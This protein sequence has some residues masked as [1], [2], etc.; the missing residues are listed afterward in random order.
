MNQTFFDG[1]EPY[2]PKEDYSKQRQPRRPNSWFQTDASQLAL[3]ENT[4]TPDVIS[5]LAYVGAKHRLYKQLM[6]E[7][8]PEDTSEIVSPFMGGAS[9]ELKLA[10]S[11]MKVWAYDIFRPV[12]EFFQ[13]FNEHA[14]QVVE[15]ALQIYPI[16]RGC[17]ETRERYEHLRSEEGWNEIECPIERAAVTWC[18]SKQSYMGRNFSS[19]PVA[20]E[21]ALNIEYFRNPIGGRNNKRI[22]A[23]WHNSNISFHIGDFRDSLSNHDCIAYMDPPYVQKEKLYGFGD[24]GEFPHEELRDILA[25]RQG[26]VLSYGDHPDIWELYKD[27]KIMTPK[28]QYGFGRAQSDASLSEELLILSHDLA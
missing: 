13:V 16:Y 7:I 2:E 12:V 28:W 11:G 27:F 1:I 10:G 23:D 6:M 15:K 25:E 19:S 17:D 8:L 14:A 5:P 3:M 20:P 22:W 26:F 24:Q 4:R 18:V 9:L 21:H